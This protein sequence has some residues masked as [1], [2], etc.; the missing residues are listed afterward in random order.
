MAARC[1][2]RGAS[3][4]AQ[5][6]AS[7]THSTD[8]AATEPQVNG[9]EPERLDADVVCAALDDEHRPDRPPRAAL[10]DERCKVAISRLGERVRMAG[11]AEIGGSASRHRASSIA[12]LHRVLHGWLPAV[13]QLPQ[14]QVWNGARRMLPDRP[15]VL[16]P[17]GIDGVWLSLGPGSS[18]W[19]VACGSACLRADAV[20]RRV[21]AIDL[22][23][24]G[25][26]RLGLRR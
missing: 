11:S 6:D 23:G 15:P 24:L 17:S 9:A 21:Q 19:A 10:M 3:R 18:G 13:A 7:A 22:D 25:I 12:T 20:A 8:F 5:C 14:A 1:H 16:G 2:G 4:S 26:E